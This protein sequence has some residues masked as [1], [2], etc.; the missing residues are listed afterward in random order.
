[1][2]IRNAKRWLEFRGHMPNLGGGKE[3]RKG[4]CGVANG[5]LEREMD[6][7]ENKQEIS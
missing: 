5:F 2:G 6:P 1:L 3:W 7:K 4:T